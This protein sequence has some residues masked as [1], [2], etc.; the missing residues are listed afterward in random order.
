MYFQKF[1]LPNQS[2]VRLELEIRELR[3]GLAIVWG[4]VVVRCSGMK[5]GK[6]FMS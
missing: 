3:G 6:G 5:E 2:S 4:L 1:L